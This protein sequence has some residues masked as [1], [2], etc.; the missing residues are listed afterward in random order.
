MR[1]LGRALVKTHYYKEAIDYYIEA[2]KV[3][4][5]AINNQK[6]LNYWEIINDFLDLIKFLL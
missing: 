2:S 1:D 3:D 4:E 6:V 5:R